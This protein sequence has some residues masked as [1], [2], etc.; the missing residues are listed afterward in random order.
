MCGVGAVYTRIKETPL[1]S[2]YF[3]IYYMCTCYF[4]LGESF[5]STSFYKPLS[6]FSFS[7]LLFLGSRKGGAKGNPHNHTPL[8]FQTNL[9]TE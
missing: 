1:R 2:F 6:N 5:F 8:A 3:E 7:F 9:F 4:L